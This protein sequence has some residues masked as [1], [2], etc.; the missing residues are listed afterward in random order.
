MVGAHNPACGAVV[1]VHG[2]ARVRAR[3]E[4]GFTLIEVLIVLI[5]LA[6]L[7][8]IALPNVRT[9]SDGPSAPATAI[10]GGVVWRAVQFS[11]LEAG[12][13][14]PTTA[15]MSNR[16]A[17]LVDP[18]GTRRIQPWPETGRGDPIVMTVSNQAAPA[19]SGPPNSLAYGVAPGARPT[20]GWLA[21]YGP[22][23]QLVYRRVISPAAPVLGSTQG[24][25][26]G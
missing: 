19:N 8:A 17:G 18:A 11:R 20:S 2:R 7:M 6:I 12:G 26:A 14:M 3:A 25:P 1:R 9:A 21:G 24:A 13:V 16:A 10:A 5:I 15:E 23:G 4:A 22:K